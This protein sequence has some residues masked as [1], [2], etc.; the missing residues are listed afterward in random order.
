MAIHSSDTELLNGTAKSRIL[1]TCPKQIPPYLA[2]ELEALDFPIAEIAP[3]GV[4]TSGT[5]HD[6]YKLNLHL[7]TGHRVLFQLARFYVRT[8]DDLYKSLSKIAWEDIIPTDGY[9]SVISSVETEAISNTMFANVKCKDAIVDRIR[10]KCGSRPDSGS[11]TSKA[12]VFVYWKGLHC[13]VYLDT[14]GESLSKRGYRS[15]PGQAPMRESLVA[16]TLMATKWDRTSPFVN[17]MCGSGTIAIEA[18]LM[19]LGQAPALLRE[20]FSFMHLCGYSPTTWVNLRDEARAMLSRSKA[21]QN[22]PFLVTASDISS[23]SIAAAEHNAKAAG[24]AEYIRFQRCDFAETEVPSASDGASPVV[25]LNP[26]YGERMGEEA[27][28]ED[29]YKRIGDFFKQQCG[30]YR[31]YVFTGN[32]HLAKKIGLKASRR[33][34]FYNAD[35]ECRLLEYEL[36]S[37][38]RRVFGE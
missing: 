36:Y 24:V 28:L 38:T 21:A 33:H 29:T 27:K 34:E 17:L 8:P 5:M 25:M 35:I 14:S 22:Q 31:G 13:N 18:A 3:A 11:D 9:V 32:M 15:M 10:A 16:A 19:A 12:V 6:C 20:N 2:Q 7:R 1:V 23:A 37:G 26:E 4:F 30:G